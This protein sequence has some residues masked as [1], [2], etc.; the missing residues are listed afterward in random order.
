[1]VSS[2]GIHFRNEAAQSQRIKFADERKASRNNKKQNNATRVKLC[3]LY[4]LPFR[5]HSYN[6]DINIY[7]PSQFDLDLYCT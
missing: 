7:I 1:M 3:T 2:I 5:S 4:A 6:K